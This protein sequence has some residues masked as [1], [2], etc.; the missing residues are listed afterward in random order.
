MSLSCS[1]LFA[2]TGSCGTGSGRDKVDD[3]VDRLTCGNYLSRSQRLLVIVI[4]C[5]ERKQLTQ[6]FSP[7]LCWTLS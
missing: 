5:F 2:G 6:R 3:N 4:I 1:V 7:S